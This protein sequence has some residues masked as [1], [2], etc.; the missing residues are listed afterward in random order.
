M[1]FNVNFS[2][3]EDAAV[4]VIAFIALILA[5]IFEDLFIW[6]ALAIWIF[7]GVILILNRLGLR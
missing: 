4:F 1:K 3:S 6:I 2:I 5:L 7:I